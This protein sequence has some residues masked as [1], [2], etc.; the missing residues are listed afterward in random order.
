MLNNVDT[1][2]DIEKALIPMMINVRTKTTLYN[3]NNVSIC[4]D[5]SE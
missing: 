5:M 4:V 3:S 1:G 2:D